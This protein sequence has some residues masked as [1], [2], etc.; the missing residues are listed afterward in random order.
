MESREEEG[1]AMTIGTLNINRTPSD[2]INIVDIGT[3]LIFNVLCFDYKLSLLNRDDVLIVLPDLSKFKP[4]PF[5]IYWM[6]RLSDNE[7]S[8]F[9]ESST[10]AKMI[11]AGMNFVII[12]INKN[13]YEKEIKGED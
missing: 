6:N 12:I 4:D 1:G 3:G 13:D 10:F 11:D 2:K 5:T 9:I 7:I 8:V